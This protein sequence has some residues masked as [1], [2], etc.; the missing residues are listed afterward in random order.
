MNRRTIAERSIW[1]ECLRENATNM[2]LEHEDLARRISASLASSQKALL[3]IEVLN[4]ELLKLKYTI[5]S[6][7]VDIMCYENKSCEFLLEIL[8]KIVD[9]N[10]LD[11]QLN[12]NMI[13]TTFLDLDASSDEPLDLNDLSLV[14]SDLNQQYSQDVPVPSDENSTEEQLPCKLDTSPLQLD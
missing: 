3:D 5:N 7:I 10:D 6:A 8:I 14:R 12:P 9:T 1:M 11:A 13:S 2:R 4:N